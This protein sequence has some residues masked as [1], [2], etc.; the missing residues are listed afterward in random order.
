MVAVAKQASFGGLDNDQQRIADTEASYTWREQLWSAMRLFVE[1]YVDI[2]NGLKKYD[3][4]AFRLNKIWEDKG[5]PVTA[6]ALKQALTDSDRNNFRLEWADWF[7]SQ[8]V[9]VATLLARRVKAAQTKDEYIA[10]LETEIRD[11]LS[12]RQAEALLRRARSR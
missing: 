11:T 10:A 5:R 7:A 12:H 8:D 2:E 1:T 3:G 4:C 9:D 6:G